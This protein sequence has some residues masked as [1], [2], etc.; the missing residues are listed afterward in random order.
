MG[1][2]EEA[3]L[4]CE[5]ALQQNRENEQALELKKMLENGGTSAAP[6]ALSPEA[7]EEPEKP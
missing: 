7:P 5:K 3:S 1:R 2:K 6:G 4:C